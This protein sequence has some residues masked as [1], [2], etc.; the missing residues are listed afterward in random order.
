L[1]RMANISES[2]HPWTCLNGFW[3]PGMAEFVKR[4][5]TPPD[6]YEPTHS[7]TCLKVLSFLYLPI[8]GFV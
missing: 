3:G 4:R 8:P 2:T 1:S 6:I 7:W 5:P